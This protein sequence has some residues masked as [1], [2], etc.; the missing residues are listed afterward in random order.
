MSY[1][2]LTNRIGYCGAKVIASRINESHSY[3]VVI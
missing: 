1:Y 2:M 3:D